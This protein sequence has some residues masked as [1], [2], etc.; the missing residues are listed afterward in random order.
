MYNSVTHFIN[1]VVPPW[2]FPPPPFFFSSAA[3][4]VQASEVSEI[5]GV[6]FGGSVFGKAWCWAGGGE[7]NPGAAGGPGVQLRRGSRGDTPAGRTPALG[8]PGKGRDSVDCSC[9]AWQAPRNCFRARV[10]LSSLANQLY[11]K[12]SHLQ[13]GWH[14]AGHGA[15]EPGGSALWDGRLRGTPAVVPPR[16]VGNLCQVAAGFTPCRVFQL[17]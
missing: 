1:I 13:P 12:M 9:R 5:C 2:T 7:E 3:F 11:E 15:A 16:G 14:C 6:V 10:F 17:A 8:A 4:L